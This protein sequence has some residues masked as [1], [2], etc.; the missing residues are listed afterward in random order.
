MKIRCRRRVSSLSDIVVMKKM[1]KDVQKLE[2]TDE[3]L[4][5]F[6]EAR[7][8]LT[9]IRVAQSCCFPLQDKAFLCAQ[10]TSLCILALKPLFI[11]VLACNIVQFLRI[12]LTFKGH[13][14][15]IF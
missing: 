8:F 4:M 1:L 3:Y 12:K 5:R 6:S 15:N 7:W 14:G 11:P 13:F 9:A 10:Q 2:D